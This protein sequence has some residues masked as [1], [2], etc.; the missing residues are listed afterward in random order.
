MNNKFSFSLC[1]LFTKLYP[2]EKLDLSNVDMS[3]VDDLCQEF[4]LD[5]D[6]S[7]IWEGN[8][9]VD[10]M[11]TKTSYLSYLLRLRRFYYR[12]CE[13]FT[14][15]KFRIVNNLINENNRDTETHFRLLQI[16]PA[17]KN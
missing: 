9:V 17:Q 3:F 8:S 6:I 11:M 7:M 1:D 13:P 15:R 16:T 5:E 14:M 12:S 4:I 10:V 2:T